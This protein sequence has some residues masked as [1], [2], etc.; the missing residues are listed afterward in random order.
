M[1]LGCLSPIIGI[2]LFIFLIIQL[3][4]GKAFLYGFLSFIVMFIF[5]MIS[6]S[7]DLKKK[8]KQKSVLYSLKPNTSHIQ[9][10]LSYVSDDLLSKLAIDDVNGKFYIWTPKNP[11]IKTIEDVTLGMPYQLHK[12]NQSDIL[13]V[14]F[15][16]DGNVLSYLSRQSKK[17]TYFL[18]GLP[19]FEVEPITE[20]KSEHEVNRITFKIIVRDKSKPIHL[21]NFYHNLSESLQKNFAE[22][23]QIYS[24]IQQWL[25]AFH[26]MMKEADQ[27]EGFTAESIAPI[28]NQERSASH[29]DGL[30]KSIHTSTE[31]N[32]LIRTKLLPLL[33]EVI[34]KRVQKE[35]GFTTISENQPS[36]TSSY[37]DELLKKNREM[38]SKKQPLQISWVRLLFT[39]LAGK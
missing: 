23:K 37:F 36:Q 3:E 17:A 32:M 35:P 28:R 20:K 27:Q 31:Q 14:E 4:I 15:I 8:E 10:S 16:E 22:Y 24:D 26:L 11:E 13:S 25:T 12:Y 1:T 2:G 34:H 18:E 19:T 21:F 39:F 9:E 5:A 29:S 38:M 7:I 6:G 30:N 33:R